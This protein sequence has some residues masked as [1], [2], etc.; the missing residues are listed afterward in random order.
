MIQASHMQACCMLVTLFDLSTVALKDRRLTL[1]SLLDTVGDNSIIII[2]TCFKSIAVLADVTFRLAA[3]LF[4]KPN[5]QTPQVDASL[6]RMNDLNI[7]YKEGDGS[8]IL[9]DPYVGNLIK[10]L[11]FSKLDFCTKRLALLG[12]NLSGHDLK[13]SQSQVVEKTEKLRKGF[14]N[15]I[16][17]KGSEILN[18]I[19]YVFHAD[20][21][22]TLP[23][24]FEQE[25]EESCEATR[26]TYV[27]CDKDSIYDQP[28][29]PNYSQ[30]SHDGKKTITDTPEKR[31]KYTH[32]KEYI[33]R[34]ATFCHCGFFTD[35]PTFAHLG[36]FYKGMS[37]RVSC[38]ECGITLSNWKKDD[39]PLLEHIRYSPECRHLATVVDHVFLTNC[40]SE[41]Q[42]RQVKDSD[43]DARGVRQ[44]QGDVVRCYAC[45]GGLRKWAQGDDAWKEHCKWFPD[46]PHLQQSNFNLSRRNM[47]GE[48]SAIKHKEVTSR[49]DE[50]LS[51]SG[52]LARRK[53]QV[54]IGEKNEKQEDTDPDINSPAALAAQERGYSKRA[55]KMVIH[56]LR[57][58][59]RDKLTAM[60]IL[61]CL[62]SYE[63]KGIKIP[64]DDME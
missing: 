62:L 63:E 40:K 58:K 9:V 12:F 34:L 57:G 7:V 31:T 45:D 54:S 52:D 47:T 32:L 1:A 41:F 13:N 14:W 29:T 8:Y 22:H 30:N 43:F 50:R 4:R 49:T 5:H 44:G 42:R 55:V 25:F 53:D 21:G 51:P 56:E 37:D 33:T 27:V 24:Y 48:G 61:D 10:N 6:L 3:S 28:S 19:G 17:C 46:C 18:N 60:N 16:S 64:T 59:G 11:L 2:G 23:V 38:Y 35:H 20:G 15:R 36:F 39:D 26:I